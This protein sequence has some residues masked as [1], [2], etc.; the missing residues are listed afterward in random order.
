MFLINVIKMI[1]RRKK[2]T[3]YIESSDDASENS[4]TDASPSLRPNQTSALFLFESDIRSF[5]NY[6]ATSRCEPR[7]GCSPNVETVMALTNYQ[8]VPSSANHRVASKYFTCN[9]CSFVCT[10]AYD[11]SLHLRQKHGIHRKL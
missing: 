4:F 8:R 2:R 6:N 9:L 1:P 7:A 3:K 11:L 5:N 10:W